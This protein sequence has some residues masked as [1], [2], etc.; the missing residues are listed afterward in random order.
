VLNEFSPGVADLYRE[1]GVLEFVRWESHSQDRAERFAAAE[2]AGAF[3][4][5]LLETNPIV[6]NLGIWMLQ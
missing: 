2:K 1:T 5:P 6:S 4:V 3:Y